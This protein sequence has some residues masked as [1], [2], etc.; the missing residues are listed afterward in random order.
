MSSSQSLGQVRPPGLFQGGAGARPGQPRRRSPLLRA[1]GLAGQAQSRDCRTQA[2]LA[3]G[4]CLH[5]LR[6]ARRDRLT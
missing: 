1:G 3:G 6:G 5:G 4:G 2:L